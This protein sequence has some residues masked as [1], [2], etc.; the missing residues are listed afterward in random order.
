MVSSDVHTRNNLKFGLT[1][2]DQPPPRVLNHSHFIAF[3]KAQQ[4]DQ[5]SSRLKGWRSA[6]K[7]LTRN[8]CASF[9]SVVSHAQLHGVKSELM[10]PLLPLLEHGPFASF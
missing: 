2:L 4:N 5:K 6:V 1:M 3:P 7:E 9:A 10:A 8:P